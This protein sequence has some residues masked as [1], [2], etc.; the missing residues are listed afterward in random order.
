M[1]MH[2][3]KSTEKHVWSWEGW[4]RGAQGS[5]EGSADSR[6]PRWGQ[7]APPGGTWFWGTLGNGAHHPAVVCSHE[8]PQGQLGVTRKRR[9]HPTCPS[10]PPQFSGDPHY[11]LGPAANPLS[12]RVTTGAPQGWYQL[13]SHPPHTHVPAAW[14]QWPLRIRSHLHPPSRTLC[15]CPCVR[16]TFQRAHAAVSLLPQGSSTG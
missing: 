3:P 8:V 13:C 10:A 6:A 9:A 14:G 5:T 4:V 11:V 15:S 7:G 2:Q 12:W 16:T 1:E